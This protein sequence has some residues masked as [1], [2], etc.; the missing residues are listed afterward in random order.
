[1]IIPRNKWNKYISRLS[2]INQAAADDILAYVDKH[3]GL[4]A[5]DRTQL[6]DYGYY[7]STKYGEA[8]AALS[9]DMY[10]AVAEL[11]RAGVPAALPAETATYS[12]VAKTVNGIIKNTNSEDV[13]A[14][15]ISRLV[16]RAGTD[17]MLSNA[18]RDRP[19]GKGS[20]KRH[21]GA[22]AAWVPSGDTCPYCL[23]L[24]SKGWQY[25]TEWA[26]DSHAEHIHAN[27]NCSY[28]VRFS[29]DM[30]IEGYDPEEY[31]EEYLEAGDNRKDRLN[32]M[33]REQY[34]ENKDKIN[35]QKREAYAE[36]KEREMTEGP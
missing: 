21:S 18:Y 3:G 16:K 32:A 30:D 24:A 28:M 33:R 9:A 31:R 34:D 2:R 23:M 26:E 5:I 20:K 27:C 29:E 17:T 22:Q 1:M 10:D 11:S 14:Q 15:G 8:S 6:I 35:E 19:R 7:V 13:L 12:D 25:Q 36:R 4:D